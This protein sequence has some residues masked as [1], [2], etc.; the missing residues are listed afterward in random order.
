[1]LFKKTSVKKYIRNHWQLYCFI[2]IPLIYIIIFSYIPMIGIILAFKDYRPS[3][4]ILGSP[5]VGIL[6]FKEFFSSPWCWT[7]IRNTLI[8]NFYSLIAGFPIP[9]ILAIALNEIRDG[10]FK[11]IV[12]TVTFAPYFISTTV[13]VGLMIQFLSLNYG[14]INLLLKS[15]GLE[16]IDFMGTP[17]LFPHIY[18]WSGIWQGAG[19]GALIYLAA[20]STIDPELY[21]A[22]KIDGANRLQKIWY[23]DLPGISPTIIILLIMSLGAVMNIG[24]EKV[25]L[26]QNSLN[27]DKSEVISTYVYKVGL[28]DADYS[29]STAVGLFNSVVNFALLIVANGIAKKFSE[30][31][32]W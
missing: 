25:Y 5:W 17:E 26:M 9:I 2:S 28:I 6:H 29:Y 31:S 14:P 22:A 4:G 3:K 27:L 13:L 30:T 23:I 8:L 12:Q 18:V 16:P 15:I 20:L 19:Y 11:K 7:I 21:D 10:L 24:F 1:M 32:L